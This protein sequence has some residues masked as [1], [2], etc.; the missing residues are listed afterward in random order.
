ME[1]ENWVGDWISD[2]QWI[3]EDGQG[4]DVVGIAPPSSAYLVFIPS[5]YI[6]A[7]PIGVGLN[8]KCTN[9]VMETGIGAGFSP[10]AYHHWS[11]HHYSYM[12][13]VCVTN[14]FACMIHK[15]SLIWWSITLIQPITYHLQ[16][17]HRSLAHFGPSH[18]NIHERALQ[19]VRRFSTNETWYIKKTKLFAYTVMIGA[20]ADARADVTLQINAIRILV[21]PDAYRI[22]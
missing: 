21:K 19:G 12:C 3:L 15:T 16:V 11:T 14:V 17:P 1:W 9:R 7:Y 13:I 5:G 10:S 20:R 22:G 8:G 6:L 18:I 4:T 2:P